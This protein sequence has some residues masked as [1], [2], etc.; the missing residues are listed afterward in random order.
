MEPK[1]ISKQEGSEF[2]TQIRT[3]FFFF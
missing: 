2:F 3:E 1:I